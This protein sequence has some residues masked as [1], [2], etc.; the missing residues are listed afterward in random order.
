LGSDSN[1]SK[2]TDIHTVHP[3]RHYNLHGKI[4]YGYSMKTSLS[5]QIG[6]DKIGKLIK[7]NRNETSIKQKK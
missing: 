6:N 4:E 7:F 2:R 1:T 3:L 5:I